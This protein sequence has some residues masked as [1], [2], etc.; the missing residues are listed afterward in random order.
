M[1][2][3]PLPRLRNS[4]KDVATRDDKEMQSLELNR[5]YY[6][7]C[8]SEVLQA[9]CPHIARR[10]AA[11]LIGWGSE[12]LGHDDQFSKRY[13]WGPRVVLFLT[14]EDHEAW[15]QRLLAVLQERIPVSFLGYPTRY[16]DQ[17]PPQPTTN[18]KANL[19]IAITTCER[20]VELYLGI[21]DMDLAVNPLPSREWL[22]INEERLLRFTAGE[23]YHDSVGKLTELRKRFAYFPDDVWRYRL[24]YQWSSLGWD[25]D[26][27]GIC[28]HRGD[29]LSARVA[30]ARSVERI[31]GL[32]FLLNKVYRPGYLKWLHRQ[33][34]RLPYLAAE[35]GPVLEQAMVC[36]DPSDATEALYPVLDRLI[37]FQSEC[38]GVPIPDYKKP[39]TLD[40]GFFAFDLKA[41]VEGVRAS[42]KG[43]LTTL[44]T[45]VGALDQWVTD[46]D[47]LMVPRQL[48]LLE[49]VYDSED[50]S[51]ELLQRNRLEDMGL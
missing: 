20:F 15:S 8:I 4:D 9:D 10:H 38:A 22:L 42:I 44:R 51:K 49:E 47:L 18:P 16:T 30:T 46:Q 41:V 21:P 17:G 43:E 36:T 39:P 6:R 24:A 3:T 13:G 26:L 5:A 35:V 1:S 31:I 11:A 48:R 27:I 50:P 25:I 7:D 37:A 34:F 14:K 2:L 23:V 28:A 33:F 19:G 32:V 29:T 40:P 45:T 12:V